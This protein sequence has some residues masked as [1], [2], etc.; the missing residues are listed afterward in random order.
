MNLNERLYETVL[1][2][3]Q[4]KDCIIVTSDLHMNYGNVNKNKSNNHF[5][6]V[7]NYILCCSSTITSDIQFAID[8]LKSVLEKS[9]DYVKKKTNVRV[10]AQIIREIYRKTTTS[11]CVCV[12]W[13]PFHGNQFYLINQKG[14]L[15]KQNFLL[16]QNNNIHLDKDWMSGY[17]KKK[18]L[19]FFK[20]ICSRNSFY[21]N[22]FK[23]KKKRYN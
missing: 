16:T 23:R 3:I 6:L 7:N 12:G 4:L 18:K 15:F 1:L 5:N 13:D 14:S 11:N 8:Y 19:L 10:V 17:G 20:K 21:Y 22:N 9:F 2:V